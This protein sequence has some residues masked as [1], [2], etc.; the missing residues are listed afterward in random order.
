MVNVVTIQSITG[1]SDFD[2]WVSS[3]CEEATAKQYIGTFDDTELPYSFNIPTAFQN[4]AFCVRI[5]D[6]NDCKICECFGFGPE[7]TPSMTPS[8]TP[9]MT[10]TPTT[11]PTPTPTS[12]CPTPTYYNANIIANNFS[13]NVTYTLSGTL[14]N[15]K[16]QW[17]STSNGTIRWNGFRWEIA[18]W[19]PTG[20]FFYNTNPT[21]DSPDT[22]SWVYQNCAPRQTCSVSFTTSGCGV[23]LGY[24][25]TPTPTPSVTP[26][27]TS[28]QTPTPT[29]TPS[30]TNTPTPSL[31]AGATPNPTPTPTKTPTK[32]PT[33]TP[34]NTPTITQTQTITPTPTLPYQMIGTN[35]YSV[36]STVDPVCN[37][38]TGNT[39]G[40]TTYYAMVDEATFFA[41]PTS[42]VVYEYV[43]SG[44]SPVTNGFIARDPFGPYGG[45]WI[46][47]NDSGG[48]PGQ[49]VGFGSCTGASCGSVGSGC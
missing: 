16:S 40:V 18:G 2:V 48:T 22:T 25:P 43:L 11:T 4:T 8:L 44:F 26:T 20:V 32:T 6:D 45:C 12:V 38:Y 19:S 23:P 10:V 49:V 31:S 47:I 21:V 5:Y 27:Q 28:T 39:V 33:N 7:P 41:C 34:T 46:E 13:Y 1:A 24:T 30:V 3:S 42:Y 37:L 15:G 35:F 14:Y 29:P 9:T 17:T 36:K